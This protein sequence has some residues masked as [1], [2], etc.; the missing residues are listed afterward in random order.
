MAVMSG[1]KTLTSCLEE[2]FIGLS[3][4]RLLA[5]RANG[6]IFSLFSIFPEHSGAGTA[7]FHPLE[8]TAQYPLGCSKILNNF[9]PCPF[10][11]A[12]KESNLCL[13]LLPFLPSF[14]KADCPIIFP[15]PP[16]SIEEC[17]ISPPSALFS[18]WRSCLLVLFERKRERKN[19]IG[20][21][22][23][24]RSTRELIWNFEE[25]GDGV[26]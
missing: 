8:I 7:F 15:P 24:Q 19:L 25:G 12:E 23:V 4:S 3:P 10:F 18:R 5:D 11:G 14:N 17:R 21:Y 1:V 13:L 9:I 26:R 6:K 20:P 16:P 22:F 2:M